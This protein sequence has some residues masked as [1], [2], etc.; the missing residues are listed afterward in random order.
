MPHS[1]PRICTKPGCNTLVLKGR[2][3]KHQEHRRSTT[4]HQKLYSNA[5]WRKLRLM[6]LRRHPLCVQCQAEGITTP[7]T[8]VDHITPHDG[9]IA[10]MYDVSNLQGLCATHHSRK[11][12]A[13]SGFSE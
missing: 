8:Q 13:E 12:A 11:T 3:A 2:C 6:H 10:L 9:N 1:A 4:R 5:R 7:A